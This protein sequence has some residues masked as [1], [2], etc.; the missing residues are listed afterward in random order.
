[1]LH[2]LAVRVCEEKEKLRLES[3]SLTNVNTG[4]KSITRICELVLP[5][6]AFT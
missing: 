1:M 4:Q 2:K 5:R 6:Q 3:L